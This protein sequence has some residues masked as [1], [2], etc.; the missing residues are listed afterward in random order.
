MIN[1][2]L[3]ELLIRIPASPETDEL[4]DLLTSM[5][6]E[7]ADQKEQWVFRLKKPITYTIITDSSGHSYLCPLDKREEVGRSLHLIENYWEAANY[8]KECPEDLTET[9]NL[10]RLEGQLLTFTNPQIDGEPIKQTTTTDND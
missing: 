6:K 9:L 2:Q 1:E 5:E 8:D 7:R 3:R 4:Q 10:P